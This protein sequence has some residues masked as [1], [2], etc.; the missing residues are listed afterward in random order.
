MHTANF[1]AALVFEIVNPPILQRRMS[2]GAS[3]AA[4]LIG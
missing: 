2:G 1:R 4:G 3:R